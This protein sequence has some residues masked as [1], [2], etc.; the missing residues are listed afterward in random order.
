MNWTARST[1][2][3][4]TLTAWLCLGYPLP[5]AA[6]HRSQAAQPTLAAEARAE[7]TI[8]AQVETRAQTPDTGQNPDANRPA[9]PTQTSTPSSEPD[10][11]A[12]PDASRTPETPST[13]DAPPAANIGE[14]PRNPGRLFGVLPNSS[15]IEANTPYVDV[16]TKQTFKFAVEQSF[17]KM[18][19]PFVGVVALLGVGQPSEAYWQRY[20][21]ALTDNAV[22]NFNT[23]ALM[24]LLFQQDP[25]YFQLGT[26]AIWY[27]VGYA[28]SRIV[29]THSRTGG[30]RRFNVSELGGTAIAG[31]V[32]NVY[33][34]PAQSTTSAT[35][36]RIGSQVMW[37]TVAFEA[38]EFWPDIRR[39]LEKA[40]HRHRGVS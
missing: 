9:S 18:V 17:D 21:R 26:G 31:V 1:A 14:A 8:R 15:T 28:A 30:H 13:P 7:V 10:T 3:A 22:S 27:R 11:S 5:A 20:T 29:V 4:G 36:A 33:Y 37:D 16:T 23:N 32:S 24:P 2:L 19:Y 40:F 39:S 6:A 12:A 25:R 35:L 38:K 34:P